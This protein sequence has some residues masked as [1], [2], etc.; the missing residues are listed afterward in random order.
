MPTVCFLTAWKKSFRHLFPLPVILVAIG[1]A[2][3]ISYAFE[4]T[5]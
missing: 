1:I 4:V 3:T 2:I 5:S